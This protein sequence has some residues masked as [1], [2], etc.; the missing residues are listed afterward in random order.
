MQRNARSSSH[1]GTVRSQMRGGEDKAAWESLL[2]VLHTCSLPRLHVR[3]SQTTE[4]SMSSLASA[5]D[6]REGSAWRELYSSNKCF[7]ESL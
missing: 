5:A 2:A 4:V 7:D 6:A 3:S 1:S